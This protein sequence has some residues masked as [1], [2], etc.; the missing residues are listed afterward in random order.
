MSQVQLVSIE[1]VLAGL[2][3]D[4]KPIIELNENDMIEW[5]GEALEFIGAYTQLIEKV[6]NLK[7]E[8]YKV[9]VPSGL[10]N[11]VQ[12]AYKH[13]EGNP[14]TTTAMLTTA[15]KCITCDDPCAP[16]ACSSC[17]SVCATSAQLVANAEL[18]LQYY[19][20]NSFRATNYYYDHY[21]PLTRA[22]GPFSK[23]ATSGCTSCTDISPGCVHEYSLDWPYIQ[24]SFKTG[25]ICVAYVSQ[26]LDDRGWPMIPD[27]VSYIEAIKRYI[28]Y[29]VK[30]AEFLQGHLPGNIFTKLEDDW[31]WY[32]QQARNKAN[33]P[34]DIDTLENLRKQHIRLLPKVQRYDRFF[35]NLS[36][37]EKLDLKN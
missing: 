25:Y 3:R 32:C 29:K 35:G 12:I 33:M 23:A 9:L 36:T 28:T 21:R 16:G 10:K 30:Y 27:E 31:H 5:T 11:I 4:L 1:R 15:D 20:P 7:I 26:P 14:T 18:F 13:T 8:D 34:K 24:T 2:Y 19:K 37:R 17:A 22:T 6:V